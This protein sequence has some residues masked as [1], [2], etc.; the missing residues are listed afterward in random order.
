MPT[1]PDVDVVIV[2]GG[3]AGLYATHR[4][5]NILGLRVQSFEAGSGPG[6]TWYWNRYPGARCDIE[7][8]WYSY[9]FDEDLQREWRWSERFA[10]QPEILAYLEHVADRF[11]LHRSY[12]FDTRVT[13]VVWSDADQLWTVGTDTGRSVT[14]RFVISAAGVLSEPK[15]D[16]F[17]GLENFRGEIFRTSAW[18]HEGVDL[19]GKRVAVIGTGSTGI[20]II[21][22][23]ARVAAHLTVFQRTPNFASPLGNR[24]LTDVE[25]NETIANYPALRAASR[26]NFLGAPYPQAHPSALLVDEEARRQVYEKYYHG[27]AFRMLISTFGDLLFDKQANDTAADYIR[28]RIRARVTDPKVAEMLSPGD[29]HPYGTK[30]APFETDYYEAF[31]RDN[32]TLVDL[33]A[34]PIETITSTGLRTSTDDHEFDALILAT[35]FDALTGPLLAMNVAGRNGVPLEDAWSDG[36]QTYLGLA[37]PGF[38]NLFMITG[39]QSPSVA[40][41]MPMAIED[42][43][44]FAADVIAAMR[45]R[46]AGVFE[47]TEEAAQK[48]KKLVVGIA[49]QTL[50][51][52][53][54]SSSWY[55]GTNVPGKPR[56]ALLFIGGA[57]LYR[58][59]CA[60]VEAGGYGGFAIDGAAAPTPPTIDLDPAV[61]IVLGAMLGQEQRPFEA[62]SLAEQRASTEGLRAL[63]L[64]P[65]ES[66]RMVTTHYP[67][68]DGE[69]PVRVYIPRNRGADLPVVVFFHP[70]GWITGSIEVSDEPCSALADE[71]GAVVVSPSYRLAPENPFPAATDDT[72]AALR[73]AAATAREYGGDPHRMAVAGESAGGTLAAVAAH[74]VRDEG[75]P[76]LAA[77]VLLYPPIDPDADTAS[78][79]RYPSGPPLSTTALDLMWTQ[80]LQDPAAKESPLAV[81]S[82]APS[83]QGL[84]PTLVVTME[85]DPLRDEAEAYASR[86]AAARVPTE[87]VRIPG[88][89]HASLN[90]SAYVPRSSEIRQAVVAFLRSNLVAPEQSGAIESA[91]AH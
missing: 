75:G 28:E 39:P 53:A 60:E 29:D 84:P 16:E 1:A 82:K 81:P 32:V 44:E 46:G 79:R 22:E 52:L 26:N 91:A 9:S 34:T 7:S 69:R 76:A 62:L 68:G 63:Q 59:I 47:A 5:R 13:S 24:P 67:S 80:Y 77:Q 51:P 71:L 18:P 14:A 11:D 40:Y 20:Q 65:R 86:L 70:G 54:K 49:D 37:V 27:G 33:R 45:E 88:L 64:P 41:N 48:W 30:R 12:E 85:I 43:V 15:A 56:V 61:A 90:M 19:S 10:A 36:P 73:W 42:H 55:L 17:A 25:L 4:V 89:I 8:L 2:G 35:G 58:A 6:G 66:V 57:P 87:V 3:F 31:N 83:L 50:L 38:P 78:R 23:T 21:P 72:V 74:R